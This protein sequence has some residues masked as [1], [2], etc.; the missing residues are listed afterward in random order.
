[1]TQKEIRRNI[2]QV[3]DRIQGNSASYVNDAAIAAEVK[4][5]VD[6]VRGHLGILEQQGKVKLTKTFNGY[7]A[8]L[9]PTQRQLLRE[10]A[11]AADTGETMQVM[12]FDFHDSSQI[13]TLTGMFPLGGSIAWQTFGDYP[14]D[15]C[16]GVRV[17]FNLSGRFHQR[18]ALRLVHERLK[19]SKV[20]WLERHGKVWHLNFNGLR[21]VLPSLLEGLDWVSGV[22]V[23]EPE[24]EVVPSDLS[25]RLEYRTMVRFGVYKEDYILER[26]QKIFLSHKGG[27]KPLVRRFFYALK[28]F[29]FDPWLDEDAM[30]A[31]TELERGILQGFKVSCAAVFFITPNYQ[32]EGYLRTEINYAVAEKRTKND[33]FAIIT[34]VLR[35]EAGRKGTVPD[36]LRP[37]VWKEPAT[38][39][40]AL[41]EIIRALPL[42]P[43]EPRWR[44]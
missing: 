40:E 28:T 42:E 21:A 10:E 15:Q 8:Y 20:E 44:V 14:A 37:F 30:T 25:G 7:S 6:D 41:N 4:I 33:R 23:I 36:L 5:D 11:A 16:Q 12:A 22:A 3:I 17:Q 24:T 26:Q 29:G 31:G 39:L 1:M 2:L 34:I 43:G 27:D 19:Q 18:E 9:N 35:N 13:R 38:E 32:D